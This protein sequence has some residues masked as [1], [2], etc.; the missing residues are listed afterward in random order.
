MI[1]GSQPVSVRSTIPL[2]AAA[3]RLATRLPRRGNRS[4]R[5]VGRSRDE[6]RRPVRV[7]AIVETRAVQARA[8]PVPIRNGDR[9][10]PAP[11]LR[12]AVAF[13]TRLGVR[14]W[15]GCLMLGSFLVR[16]SS[17]ARSGR[18]AT[19]PTS[20]ST[21]RSRDRSRRAGAPRPRR[22]GHF[23]ALLEPLLAAPL[24]L[25]GSTATAYRLVQF[26]NALF[27]SLAAIPIYL[28]ARRLGLGTRYA[29]ASAA[30]ALALP[31]LVFSVVPPLRSARLPARPLRA[32][33]RVSRCSAEPA[34]PAGVRRARRPHDLHAAAVRRPRRCLHRRGLPARPT[35]CLAP[36]SAAA[37]ALRRGRARGRGA[38]PESRPRLLQRRRLHAL[39]RQLP[40]LG[41]PRPALPRA[42]RRGRDRPGSRGRPSRLPR[43]GRA[44]VRVPRHPVRT[45]ADGRGRDIRRQR[46][47]PLQGAVSVHAPAAAADRLRPLS[48]RRRGPGAPPSRFS[49]LRS[50]SEPRS[51][52]SPR[53]YAARGSTTRRSSAR[54][55]SSSGT[56][57]RT[58]ALLVA[59]LAWLG[60]IL[61]I[62]ASRVEWG[63]WPVL[64]WSLALAVA[65]SVGASRLRGEGLGSVNGLRR[66][67]PVLGRRRPR[68]SRRRDRD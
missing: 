23:P 20:T 67:E 2:F 42:R 31:D 10:V 47:G 55:S 26:E 16:A 5:A 19:S 32:L 37:R 4:V 35:R 1:D 27:M 49:R 14:V 9:R 57:G 29:L 40:P 66:L 21:P 28:L 11:P 15:L 58:A 43:P 50:R 12:L 56:S 60:A 8:A 30:F 48:E 6:A 33:P 61:A 22:T 53:T 52:L 45:R 38:R 54:T 51:C 68:R 36:A 63:A 62:V 46:L 7:R 25:V 39:R 65:L 3:A 64:A 59:C 44:R 18:R 17:P 41:R 34:P 24:W 13:P